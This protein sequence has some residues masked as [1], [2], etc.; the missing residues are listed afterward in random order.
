MPNKRDQEDNMPARSSKGP[1]GKRTTVKSSGTEQ[2]VR[3]N[4]SGQFTK[5]QVKAGRSVARDKK[6]A[7]KHSAP[8][9]MKDRGD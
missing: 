3:R 6:T 8:K 1:V 7:A 5:D 2:Y 4:T 9:G